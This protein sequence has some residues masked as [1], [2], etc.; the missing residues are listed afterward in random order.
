MNTASDISPMHSLL[1]SFS[2]DGGSRQNLFSQDAGSRDSRQINIP[3]SNPL[4]SSSPLLSKRVAAEPQ[5]SS[6]T[7]P[8]SLP[9]VEELGGPQTRISDLS[10]LLPPLPGREFSMYHGIGDPQNNMLFGVNVQQNELANIRSNNNENDS[11]SM[12]FACSSFSSAAGSDFPPASDMMTSSCVD[13]SGFLQ[14][15][16]NDDI[17][18]PPSRTFVKV[19]LLV[20]D[21]F[22]LCDILFPFDMHR[23]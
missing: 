7:A 17:A 3:N 23:I 9:Q 11:L 13:E 21:L 20:L 18:N 16:E 6:S 1:N 2:Q 15:S 8:C 10:S 22:L 14:S 5:H 12:P 19:S 4:A